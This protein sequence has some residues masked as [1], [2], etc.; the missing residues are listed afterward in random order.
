MDFNEMKTIVRD[1]KPTPENKQLLERANYLINEIE[2]ER[3][4]QKVWKKELNTIEG[5]V[6]EINKELISKGITKGRQ[7]KT[8]GDWLCWCA[9]N[10][11]DP[12]TGRGGEDINE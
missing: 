12:Y 6:N 7:D 4:K 2:G 11:L 10:R 8:W 1:C 3:I 9:T 5:R